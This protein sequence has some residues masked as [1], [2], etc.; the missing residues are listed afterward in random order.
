ME[1]SRFPLRSMSTLGTPLRFLIRVLSLLRVDV[2]GCVPLYY[3]GVWGIPHRV[4]KPR[5]FSGE[6]TVRV[7]LFE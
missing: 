6:R 1:R 3:T 5:L 7:S 4:F 2:L